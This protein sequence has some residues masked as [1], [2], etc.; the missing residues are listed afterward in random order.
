MNQQVCIMACG[1]SGRSAAQVGFIAKGV[2]YALIGGLS[3]QSA[4]QNTV[5]I[6]GADNS[7]QVLLQPTLAFKSVQQ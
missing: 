7:P 4:V 5:T 3:C 2:V 6:R 1:I